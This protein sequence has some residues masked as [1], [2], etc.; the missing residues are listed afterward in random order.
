MRHRYKPA[1]ALLVAVAIGCASV[2]LVD[3]LLD[4][5]LRRLGDAAA[6]R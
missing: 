6:R 4:E 5:A 2:V 3:R 1:E